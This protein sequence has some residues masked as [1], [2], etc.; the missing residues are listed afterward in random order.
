[1][2]TV[3]G[4]KL[5]TCRAIAHDALRA[6]QGRLPELAALKKKGP[7]LGMPP[8]L[9]DSALPEPVRL[10]LRGRYGADAP[11]LVAAARPGELEPIPETSTLWAELRWAARSEGVVHLEDLLLR[12]T[13]LGLLLPRGGEALLPRLRALCQLELGWDDARW[14]A[15]E[16]AYLALWRAHYSPPEPARLP[17]QATGTE[18]ARGQ[19]VPPPPSGLQSQ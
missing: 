16:R 11:A 18:A 12:R 5:T 14:E 9:E 17:A 6:L 13:R 10:R 19:P 15:E 8:P 3:T 1:L 4:G 7:F 2:L